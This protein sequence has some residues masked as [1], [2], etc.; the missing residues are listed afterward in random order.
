M[1]GEKTAPGLY[2]SVAFLLECRAGSSRHPVTPFPPSPG[3]ASPCWEHPSLPKPFPAGSGLPSQ[4]PKAQRGPC[5][6]G[7]AESGQRGWSA[8]ID[9]NLIPNWLPTRTPARPGFELPGRTNPRVSAGFCGSGSMDSSPAQTHCSL[10]VPWVSPA[11]RGLGASRKDP[12]AV[13]RPRIPSHLP[14]SCSRGQS[15][16]CDLQP[17]PAAFPGFPRSFPGSLV[18]PEGPEFF[19]VFQQPGRSCGDGHHPKAASGIAESS[20]RRIYSQNYPKV[21][22]SFGKLR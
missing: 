20:A 9:R 4:D 19:S 11:S 8:S 5:E 12:S 21:P 18:M 6:S 10:L 7:P 17:P 2:P 14:S 15:P 13:A 3:T 22:R 1:E 16:R